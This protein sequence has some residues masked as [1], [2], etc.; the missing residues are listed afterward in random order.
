MP[1]AK[2]GASDEW[3]AQQADVSV[4][5][6]KLWRKQ[7]GLSSDKKSTQEAM[8]ALQG[9][10]L[11]YEPTAHRTG[12]AFDWETPEFL[13]RRPLDYTQYA[14]SCFTLLTIAMFTPRQIARATGTRE[15]D[16]E[17]AIALWR[18]HLSGHGTRC[19]G[20]DSLVDTRY[21]EFCSRICHDRATQR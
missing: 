4:R 15:R 20:C 1:Q 2:A 21:T 17:Q 18:R 8:S 11:A 5:Q 19:L 16:V 14:R 12:D 3:L 6:V 10:A 7:R 13:L 9:L